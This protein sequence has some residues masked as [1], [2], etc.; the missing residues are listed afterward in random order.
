MKNKLETG[1]RIFASWNRADVNK[2]KL[3][4]KIV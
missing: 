2:N 3:E 4:R 1:K